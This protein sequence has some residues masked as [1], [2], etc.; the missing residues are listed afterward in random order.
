[1]DVWS[2]IISYCNIIALCR[3]Q[4]VSK[5]LSKCVTPIIWKNIFLKRFP[6]CYFEFSDGIK[7][8]HSSL[9][10]CPNCFGGKFKAKDSKRNILCC[11]SS[12]QNHDWKKLLK[13]R[14][15]TSKTILGSSNHKICP[16]IGC[17]KILKSKKSYDNHLSKEHGVLSCKRQKCLESKTVSRSLD[18]STK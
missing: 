5:E 6:K 8:V 13:E 14:L 17:L 9:E 12:Q 11:N 4:C 10:S 2:L 1:M 3:L 16:M 18:S 7:Y 15:L